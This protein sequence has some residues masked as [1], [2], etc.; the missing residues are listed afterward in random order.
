MGDDLTGIDLEKQDFDI[1]IN[2]AVQ[3]LQ[4]VLTIKI[5][6]YSIISPVFLADTPS[7]AE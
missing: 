7:L 4:Y 6:S 5:R 2:P 3:I 1:S